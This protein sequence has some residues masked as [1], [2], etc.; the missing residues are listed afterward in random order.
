MLTY[1]ILFFPFN[2]ILKSNLNQTKKKV[3]IFFI[4]IIRSISFTILSIKQITET[5]FLLSQI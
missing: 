3:N 5:V 4:L 1:F 2:L